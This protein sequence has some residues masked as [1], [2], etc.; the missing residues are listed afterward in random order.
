[1]SFLPYSWARSFL[2]SMDAE[3]AHEHTLA[4]LAKTQNTPGVFCVLASIASVC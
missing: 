1:M 4:M 2:F 3:V